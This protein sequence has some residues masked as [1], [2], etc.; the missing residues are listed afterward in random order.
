[1]V[2]AVVCNRRIGPAC[3]DTD[4]VRCSAFMFRPPRFVCALTLGAPFY[5]A[6]PP[7]NLDD[8]SALPKAEGLHSSSLYQ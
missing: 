8:V 7:M 2:C 4:F 5:Q 1:M 6:G 3:P